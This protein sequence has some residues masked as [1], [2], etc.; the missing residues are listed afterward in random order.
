VKEVTTM[1][2]WKRILILSSVALPVVLAALATGPII[3]V[4]AASTL[5]VSPSGTDS[6]TCGAVASPCKTISQAIANA[7]VG[8][9]VLVAAGT[10][11]ESVTLSK[12]LTLQGASAATVIIDATGLVNG[13]MLGA[14]SSGSTV[15]GFTVKNATGEGILAMTVANITITQ[16]VVTGND[17]GSGTTA[18][19]ECQDQGEVPG[20]CGEGI[21]LMTV[22]NGKVIS[23]QVDHNV[24]GILVTDE[25][26]PAHDNLISNNIVQNNA[27]DCGI[28]LPSHNGGALSSAGARQPT[29][30]GVYNNT[31]DGNTIT[32]NGG[33]GVLIAA[34]FPGT[35]SYGNTIT[36]NTIAGNGNSGVTFHSHAPN[37]D[38]NGNNVSNN[39]IGVN[40]VAGDPDAN[41]T[42]TTGV[43]VF[44]AVMPVTSITISANQITGD[45]IGIWVGSNV[46]M[47]GVSN[48]TF[49]GVTTNVQTVT[50]PA[51][52]PPSAPQAVPAP[53]NT[54][55]GP[56][57]QRDSRDLAPLIVLGILFALAGVGSWRLGRG[58]IPRSR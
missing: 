10:Y 28:T 30:A 53:P 8:D 19:L 52:P 47:A 34:P 5:N 11:H 9:T 32:N 35:A 15:Q 20:D 13:V 27:L 24:G 39:T 3:S 37:Q 49:V 51:G 46:S 44:S 18:T 57:L 36:H 40:N 56:V 1:V 33:A 25:M 54:G 58:R 48:N 42:A 7:S 50:I 17:K 2:H 31:V 23:N 43:L 22:A 41:D 55:T 26:G 16:N 4:L 12:Q 38:I 14:G 45:Q 6:A 29:V 21:H